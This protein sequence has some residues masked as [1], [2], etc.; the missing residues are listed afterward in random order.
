M[1]VLEVCVP[2]DQQAMLMTKPSEVITTD[3]NCK[4]E[5]Y[6]NEGQNVMNCAKEHG[7]TDKEPSVTE[8]LCKKIKVGTQKCILELKVECFSERENN[9][10]ADLLKTVFEDSKESYGTDTGK[11]VLREMKPNRREIL[12][13]ILELEGSK[14][15]ESGQ[16][17][18]TISSLFITPLIYTIL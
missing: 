14:S 4:M 6:I 3:N 7:Y 12:K 5:D 11:K 2:S 1:K 8:E 9:V 10:L 16:A 17:S 13:C 18:V 15:V